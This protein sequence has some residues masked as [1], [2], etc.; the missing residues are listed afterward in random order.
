MKQ[1]ILVIQYVIFSII[2]VM[3]LLSVIIFN[4]SSENTIGLNDRLFVG[5]FFILSCLIGITLTIYPGWIRRLIKNRFQKPTN[6]NTKKLKRN[7]IGHHPDCN[8]FKNHTIKIKNRI[9]CAGCLGLAIGCIISIFLMIIYVQNFLKISSDIFLYLIFIG[10]LII[11]FV[12]IEIMFNN[13]N[14]LIHITSNSL[15]VL[16]FLLIIV[17]IVEITGNKNYGIISIL[18]SFLW[19]DTR[20]Q[21]SNWHHRT[22]CMNCNESC[23][24]Y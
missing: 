10:F 22:I 16:G 13:R 8:E 17:S 21:L 2:S 6:K 18:F 4:I 14:T 9:H 23:K 5:I 1:S 7:R 11:G 12:F 19:L 3:L 24:M 15:L 20:I